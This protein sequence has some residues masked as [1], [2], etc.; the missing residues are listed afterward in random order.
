MLFMYVLGLWINYGTVNWEKGYVT[1]RG[2]RHT[3]AVNL[4]SEREHTCNPSD[5]TVPDRETGERERE[6]EKRGK[7]RVGWH[8]LRRG[9]EVADRQKDKGRMS[10]KEPSWKMA[11]S[12]LVQDR[13]SHWSEDDI[14]P[15][16][17]PPGAD[18]SRHRKVILLF[19]LS[20]LTD[21][22]SQISS[23]TLSV[24]VGLY[25]FRTFIDT[26]RNKSF[27]PIWPMIT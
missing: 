26:D 8:C 12:F 10:E 25:P 15:F 18:I 6:R 5:L 16:R 23:L 24:S 4:P 17:A 21:C 1:L 7:D 13:S 19:P 9:R 20:Q 22:H 11:D 27:S 14:V 3:A 2:C